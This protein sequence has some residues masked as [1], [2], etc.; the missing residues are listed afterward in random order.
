MTSSW[1]LLHQPDPSHHPQESLSKKKGQT[2]LTFSSRT[3]RTPGKNFFLLANTFISSPNQQWTNLDPLTQDHQPDLPKNHLDLLKLTK[4][5][6]L[7][8]GILHSVLHEP[9]IALIHHAVVPP[10]NILN[11]QSFQATFS[12]NRTTPVIQIPMQRK[13]PPKM[14]TWTSTL[15]KSYLSY[16]DLS[17]CYHYVLFCLVVIMV[18]FAFALRFCQSHALLKHLCPFVI[19]KGV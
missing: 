16:Y 18:T 11:V 9:I 7:P 1:S 12:A 15:H 19:I 13:V 8:P 4:P 14:T 10:V 3:L 17:S 2:T 6:R 5:P